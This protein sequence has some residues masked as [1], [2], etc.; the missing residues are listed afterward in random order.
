MEIFIQMMRHHPI[1]LVSNFI[2]I[3]QTIFGYKK[4]IRTL[5]LP[6][7]YCVSLIMVTILMSS[8]FQQYT[9]STVKFTR[10]NEKNMS[11][12]LIPKSHKVEKSLKQSDQ[13]PLKFSDANTQHVEWRMS[14]RWTIIDNISS[15]FRTLL[16]SCVIFK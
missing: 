15:V 13:A 10:G 14:D 3:G 9:F 12:L 6:L 11:F 5:Q 16:F 8:I 7:T 1:N 2:L 4:R